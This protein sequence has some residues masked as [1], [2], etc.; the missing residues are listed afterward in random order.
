MKILITG[1]KGQLGSEIRVLASDYLHYE[2]LYTDVD[3]LDITN[4]DSVN[5]FFEFHSPDVVINC[6]AYTAVDKAE[7]DEENAHLVNAVAAGNLARAAAISG[8]FMVH[9]STDY[10][11]DGKNH[12]PYIETDSISPVSVYAKSK[13][14]GEDE[15]IEAQGKAVIFRTS[16]LYSAFGNNFIKAMMKYGVEREEL[17]VVFDQTGTPTYARDLAKAILDI[18]PIAM[19]AETIEIYHYSNEGVASWYDFAIAVLQMAGIYCKVNAIHTKEYPLPA[20]RPFYSVLDKSKIKKKF[21]IEI[22]Y[23]R[24]SVQNCIDR[25][26]AVN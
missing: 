8:A 26:N 16:W 17:N 14:A 10:L 4:E 12:Q 15:V 18:L 11:Y 25:L 19:T 22:P 20:E 2:F 13:A 3:E 21:G 24:T 6:A 23:W 5:Q 7:T 1:S 9:I